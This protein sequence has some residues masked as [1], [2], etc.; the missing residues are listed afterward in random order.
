[1]RFVTFEHGGSVR[2]GVLFGDASK[3]DDVVY[4][5]ANVSM[6]GALGDVP[7]DLGRMIEA[8]LPKIS[9]DIAA[10]GVKAAA[11]LHCGNV[12]L[13]APLPE[14]RRIIGVAHNY[15]DAL[16]E[17]GMEPPTS[18]IV[19]EKFPSSV[20][21][22]GETVVLPKG[23]GGVTYEAELAVV[24][25]VGGENIPVENALAHVAGYA[26]L[27]DISASEMIKADGH[28]RRGK[29]L[30]TFCP[31]GPFL[32]STDEIPDPQSLT[33]ELWM[34]GAKLQDGTTAEMLFGVTELISILSGQSPLQ[35]GDVIA[36]GT[37][38]GVAPVRKPPTWMRP[39]ADLVMT[40]QGVGTLSNPVAEGAPLDEQ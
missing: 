25:G 7:A 29:N 4:D 32:A 30:P 34:G 16:R 3:A 6:R 28:F 5:L 12:R 27:N 26:A 36:S 20:I 15:R 31:F 17:R 39:G 18:P 14:P 38:G 21:A 19:F 8:G 37:P 22:D 35:P 33:V 40:V 23:I 24:I 13:L 2:A 1:M 9:R 11:K 10:H